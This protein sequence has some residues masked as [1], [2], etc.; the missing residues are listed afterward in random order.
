VPLPLDTFTQLVRAMKLAASGSSILVAEEE[1][2]VAI[3]SLD[4]SSDSDGDQMPDSWEQQIVDADP[5]DGIDSVDD[6]MAEDDFDGD[7]LCNEHE[8]IAGTDPA[9]PD[10]VFALME[11]VRDETGG[12]TV[13]WH[14]VDGKLY[15][16]H[17]STSLADGFTPIAADIAGTSPVNQHT[18]TDA[19]G[20]SAFYMITVQ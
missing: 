12:F 6:V 5:D 3:L 2:G 20:L 7:G 10:S 4:V 19:A 16:V 17:R 1:A 9:D 14:S 18:D 8:Y 15:T 11:P 13:Q